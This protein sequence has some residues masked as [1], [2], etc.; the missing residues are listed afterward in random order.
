MLALPAVACALQSDLPS[1]PPA[2]LSVAWFHDDCAPWDGAATSLFLGVERA[3]TV[4]HPDA[5]YLHVA[6]YSNTLGFPTG[7]RIR[8]GVPGN[9]GHAQYC[10][11]ADDCVTGR[12]VSIEFSKIEANLLEGR[13]E[14]LFDRRPAI[15]GGFRA[16]RMPF[17]ALCG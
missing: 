1:D 13:L 15:R 8:F 2:G 10:L 12:A 6:L 14:V 4:F 3:K 9:Q 16:A 11:K 5:P 7:E 17:R